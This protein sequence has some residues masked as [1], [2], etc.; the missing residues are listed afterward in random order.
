MPPDGDVFGGTRPPPNIVDE[1]MRGK[2]AGLSPSREPLFADLRRNLLHQDYLRF[3]DGT[4]VCANV[5]GE[6]DGGRYAVEVRRDIVEP[7]IGTAIEQFES[8]RADVERTRTAG[9]RL[10]YD[11]IPSMEEL[12]RRALPIVAAFPE[13]AGAVEFEACYQRIVAAVRSALTAEPELRRP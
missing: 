10:P 6:I 1:A 3:F 9:R 5:L 13:A 7:A 12:H 2:V 4:L 11:P 8:I